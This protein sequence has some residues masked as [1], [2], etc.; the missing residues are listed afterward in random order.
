[1]NSLD[2][3]MSVKIAFNIKEVMAW[4]YDKTETKYPHYTLSA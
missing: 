3:K 4:L 2:C 1:M